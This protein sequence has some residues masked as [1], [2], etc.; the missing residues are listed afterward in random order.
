MPLKVAENNKILREIS[1]TKQIKYAMVPLYYENM[2]T[3]L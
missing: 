1:S 2:V 3:Y